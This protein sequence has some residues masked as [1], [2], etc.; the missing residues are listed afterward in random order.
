MVYKE[1]GKKQAQIYGD[2]INPNN[3]NVE[4]HV[5][6]G[7]IRTGKTE[8][9]TYGF[10]DWCVD[11]VKNDIE[12]AYGYN[13]FLLSSKTDKLVE[14][15][16]VSRIIY[17]GN[18]HGFIYS[19]KKH[20]FTMSKGDVQL[21]FF[22]FVFLNKASISAVTGMTARGGFVDEASFAGN[23]FLET[24]IGRF[25]TFKAR[26]KSK[27]ILTTN[28]EGGKGHWFYKNYVKNKDLIVRE[29]ELLDNP[30][31]S[32]SDVDYY[33][34]IMDKATYQK[35]ILGQWVQSEGAI[36]KRFDVD[37]HT[38]QVSND[39]IKLLVIGVDYG[40]TDGT[41]FVL[42]AIKNNF[43]GVK[44]LKEYHHKNGE[45]IDH[46]GV[47]RIKDINDYTL[48]FV[49]TT[50]DWYN[51]YNKRMLV[52]VDSANKS[53]YQ[54]LKKA[55]I[56]YNLNFLVITMVNKRTI[57]ERIDT[58]NLMIG[59]NAIEIDS[60]CVNLIDG[61]ENAQWKEEGIRLDNGTSNIDILD[62][63]EYSFVKYLPPLNTQ[64]FKKLEKENNGKS[65]KHKINW[66]H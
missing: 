38:K 8:F 19:N 64:L 66:E 6:S 5:Y 48:D 4:V 39:D 37:I 60:S 53:F 34:S 47:E 24:F 9:A 10:F 18:L 51:L 1:I 57:L 45:T 46:D 54:L 65:N 16:L 17:W 15:N 44:V 50:K 13:S 14:E 41:A 36:Y 21:K 40:E 22:T 29:F 11:Q 3:F 33:K 26:N 63:F 28:P 30:L 49:N 23:D 32:K 12:K 35:K 27:V 2:I 20:Y 61:L 58:T 62:A 7:A 31:F 56:K 55:Q 52:Q 42:T 25:A 43:L 59:S